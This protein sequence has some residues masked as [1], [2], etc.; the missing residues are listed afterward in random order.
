MRSIW[1]RAAFDCWSSN[2]VAA[3][4][5]SRRCARFTIATTISRSRNSS[6]PVPGGAFSCACRCVLKNSSGSSRIRL[7]IAGEPLRHA[8]Y[9][10]PASRVSQWCS[11]KMA[12][13][14]WQSSR[15]WRATGTRNFIATCARILP[16]RTCCWIASGRISASA[17]RR[18]TQLTLRSNRRASSSSP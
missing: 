2:S 18:D 8:P 3:A 14:R 9:S 1:C 7:R 12:A 17:S 13:I 6:A 15:L 16:S 4:P 10:W 5:A 11:A